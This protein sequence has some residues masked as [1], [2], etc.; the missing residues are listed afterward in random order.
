M[1]YKPPCSVTIFCDYFLQAGGMSPLLPPLNS[2]LPRPAVVGPM[3]VISIWRFVLRYIGC[4]TMTV[5]IADPKTMEIGAGAKNMKYKQ[6]T[7]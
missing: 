5:L 1:K 3:N 4:T 6:P 7:R 2:L